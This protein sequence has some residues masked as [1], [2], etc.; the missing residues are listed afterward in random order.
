[1]GVVVVGAVAC[2]VAAAAG[3]GGG[4]FVVVVDLHV[5]RQ[6]HWTPW[7]KM[8]RFLNEK[9]IVVQILS[10]GRDLRIKPAEISS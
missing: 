10:F 7:Q 8:C 3:G 5:M 4:G 6:T 1:M 9:T 2:G